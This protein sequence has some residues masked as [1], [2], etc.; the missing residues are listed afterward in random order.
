MLTRESYHLM[1]QVLHLAPTIFVIVFGE[2]LYKC[3]INNTGDA[4]DQCPYYLHF[5]FEVGVCNN[6]TLIGNLFY[7]LMMAAHLILNACFGGQIICIFI[8]LRFHI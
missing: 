1:N 6:L 3:I 2:K 8:S 5:F 7:L 4:H